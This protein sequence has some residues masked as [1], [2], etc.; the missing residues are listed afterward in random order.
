MPHSRRDA[1]RD[2]V[3]NSVCMKLYAV[4]LAAVL[5]C[6]AAGIPEVDKGKAL[7]SPTAPIQIEVFSDFTCPHCR[8]LHD[9]TIPLLMKDYVVP[10]KVYLVFRDFP[11]TG[12]GHQYSR[13]AFG[14][15]DAAARIGKYQEVADTLYANQATWAIKGGTWETVAAVLSPADQKKV[16]ALS[17]DPG[18]IAEI[19]RELDEGVA[20]GVNATPTLIVSSG[21]KRYPLPAPI[22]YNFLRSLLDGFLK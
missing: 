6:L 19:Q 7:G 2:S 9:Q 14:Y 12:P 22:A 13:E 18:V 5:P 17:K 15:A 8:L 16:L 21:S 11:L 1:S 10:G 4:A 3:Y 20:A